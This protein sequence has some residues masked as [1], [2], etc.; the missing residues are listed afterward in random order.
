MLA[1]RGLG[2]STTDR[3][4][5]RAGRVR[6]QVDCLAVSATIF[7]KNLPFR[8][9][10][11]GSLRRCAMLSYRKAWRVHVLTL[12]ATCWASVATARQDSHA[13]LEAGM[14]V[15]VESYVGALGVNTTD[16][17]TIEGSAGS[18]ED[19]PWLAVA[20]TVVTLAVTALVMRAQSLPS[21]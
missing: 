17:A 8:S 1:T 16:P 5:R 2:D 12:T 13:V 6:R 20:S 4:V 14:T 3:A 19:G 10:G 21:R 11:I 15:C 7:G 18:S 9:F